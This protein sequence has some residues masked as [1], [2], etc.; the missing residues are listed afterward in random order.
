MVD[1]IWKEHK[2][3]FKI[4]LALNMWERESWLK[5]SGKNTKKYDNRT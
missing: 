4:F 2:N 3:G 1:Y 5:F